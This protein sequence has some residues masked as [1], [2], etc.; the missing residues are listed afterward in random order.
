PDAVRQVRALKMGFPLIVR[1]VGTHTGESVRLVRS[2]ADLETVLSKP[3]SGMELYLTAFEDCRDGKGVYR[4]ARAFLID[5]TLYP[6]AFLGSDN[7]QLHSGDRYRIM[8]DCERLQAQERAYLSD[9]EDAIGKSRWNA[10]ESLAKSTGLD[11]VGLDFTPLEN[12]GTLMFEMNPAMRH[13]F[14][15]A[16]AFP[17][18]EAPLKRISAAFRAM[19][20]E[21]QLPQTA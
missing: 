3:A 12:G 7:W 19:L 18:T 10:L 1:R 14:D 4:K 9:P 6:V 8:R 15:H 13:N 11:F 20:A 17:Y 5:G 2:D 21:K 16:G